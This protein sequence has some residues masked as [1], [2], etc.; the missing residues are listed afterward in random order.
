MVWVKLK[1]D[2]KKNFNGNIQIRQSIF[3]SLMI[4][5]AIQVCGWCISF[6]AFVF[7]YLFVT[8]PYLKLLLA[9]MFVVS[10]NIVASSDPI[11]LLI[12]R[13]GKFKKN[14]FK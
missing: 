12:T 11:V 13:Q 9:V 5:M 8:D 1:W 14:F 2:M 7:I 10:E 4:I 6:L 3:H